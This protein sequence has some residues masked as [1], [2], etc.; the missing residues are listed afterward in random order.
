MFRAL[1]CPS[2]GAL[3][4]CSRSLRLPCECGVGHVSNRDRFVTNQPRLETRPPPH[5]HGNRRLRL[6][7][8]ELLMM[9]KIMPETCWA[10]SLWL[11]NKF[12]DRFICWMFCLN[13]LHIVTIK[14]TVCDSFTCFFSYGWHSCLQAYW[15]SIKVCSSSAGVVL[16]TTYLWKIHHSP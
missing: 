12:Y 6:Q 15:G 16:V 11:S 1:S 9:G 14:P 3:S 10:A 4:N 8:K 5:S 7:L 2:S 13:A